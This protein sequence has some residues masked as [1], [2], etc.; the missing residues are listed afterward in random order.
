MTKTKTSDEAMIPKPA[1]YAIAKAKGPTTCS[2]SDGPRQTILVNI[3]TCT[4]S[5]EIVLLAASAPATEKNE[6]PQD[7]QPDPSGVIAA[8]SVN[9]NPLVRACVNVTDAPCH[10]VPFAF[11]DLPVAP[12]VRLP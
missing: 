1:E 5:T 10:D 12:E 2:K 6:K 7:D 8:P 11:G 9:P 4:S 3:F